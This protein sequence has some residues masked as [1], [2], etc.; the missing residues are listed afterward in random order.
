MVLPALV[1]YGSRLAGPLVSGGLFAAG[2]KWAKN[3]IPN[4]KNAI[5][6]FLGNSTGRNAAFA[7]GGFSSAELFDALGIQ[8]KQF[9]NLTLVALVI[10]VVVAIAQIFNVDLNL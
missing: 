9:Q 5:S 10:G 3:L 4:A 2:S 6:K 8:N 1:S 7:I